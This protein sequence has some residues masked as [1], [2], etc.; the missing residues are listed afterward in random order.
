MKLTGFKSRDFTLKGEPYIDEKR[1]VQPSEDLDLSEHVLEG[2]ALDALVLVHVLH[3]E[4]LLGVLL[5]ND[6]HLRTTK[7]SKEELL[8]TRKQ[9][10][11]PNQLSK[12]AFLTSK[13]SR[14]QT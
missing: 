3:R 14:W 12:F 13:T 6:A 2:V 8:R 7:P 1:V 9:E 10:T 11:L 4:H 5:L